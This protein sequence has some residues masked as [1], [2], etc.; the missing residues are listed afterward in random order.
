MGNCVSE[1]DD[2]T[3]FYIHVHTGDRKG[4]GTDANISIILFDENG[5]KSEE[6]PLDNFFRND[7]ESG[8]VDKFSIKN[9]K[10]TTVSKIEVWRDSSGINDSWY[11]DKITVEN[12]ATKS[13]FIFP[14]FRWIKPE[15]HYIIKHLDTSL[16]QYDTENKNQRLMELEDK[17]KMYV[18]ATKMKGLVAQV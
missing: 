10:F 2:K 4:A 12:K 6:Y 5:G 1:V 16:P 15:Y 18:L 3:D 11:V 14:L 17:K 7:F 8:S 9:L 13:A